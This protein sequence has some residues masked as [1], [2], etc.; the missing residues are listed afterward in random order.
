MRINDLDKIKEVLERPHIELWRNGYTYD[1]PLVRYLAKFCA[2][3]SG[4][5]HK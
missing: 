2:R 1:H 3:V 5:E 4:G